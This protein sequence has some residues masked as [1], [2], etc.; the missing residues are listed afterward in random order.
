M[1][2]IM[3]ITITTMMMK[4]MMT[5]M[6][7]MM[8]NTMMMNTMMTTMMMKKMKMV[9]TYCFEHGCRAAAS[10][11]LG[12]LCPTKQKGTDPSSSPL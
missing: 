2:T 5:T 12:M 9:A 11:A 4:A 8:M 3:T 6:T 7:T 10:T 1:T